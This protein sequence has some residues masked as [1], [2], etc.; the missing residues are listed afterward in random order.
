MTSASSYRVLPEPPDPRSTRNFSTASRPLNCCSSTAVSGCNISS[1][2]AASAW[3]AVDRRGLLQRKTRLCSS[4]GCCTS[5]LP[6]RLRTL[7]LCIMV[8]RQL[9]VSVTG[10][11]SKLWFLSKCERI[12]SSLGMTSSTRQRTA[13]VGS[14]A[15][16]PTALE[17][18]CCTT[19]DVP[20]SRQP[21]TVC[22]SR[23]WRKLATTRRGPRLSMVT[24]STT[25]SSISSPSV[26]V[27]VACDGSTGSSRISLYILSK[28]PH[29]TACISKQSTQVT[30]KKNCRIP[31]SM[32]DRTY[33][34]CIGAGLI[35]PAGQPP[36]RRARP[37]RRLHVSHLHWR[38]LHLRFIVA[39]HRSHVRLQ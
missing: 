26:D 5:W 23:P 4:S 1:E 25:V 14:K 32:A 27:D 17:A 10:V 16:C 2:Q 18:I 34:R 31:A 12:S 28:T 15:S 33:L 3:W 21:T 29:C 36:Q 30:E 22:N 11:E 9:N 35:A 8:A 24:V 20:G 13:M 6:M 7:S 38:Q 37:H 19:G 39:V